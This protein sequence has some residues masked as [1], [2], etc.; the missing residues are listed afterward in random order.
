MNSNNAKRDQVA[1]LSIQLEAQP[2][3]ARQL[4]PR[5]N[6]VESNVFFYKSVAV[7]YSN[8]FSFSS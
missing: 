7:V 5:L 1:L 3:A 2:K 4:L 8:A 6:N